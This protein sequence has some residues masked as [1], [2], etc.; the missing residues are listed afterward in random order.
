MYF[1]PEPDNFNLNVELANAEHEYITAL[2]DYLKSK[3]LQNIFKNKIITVD[4]FKNK[5]N[6]D[7]DYTISIF[8]YTPLLIQ[9]QEHYGIYFHIHARD[10]DKGKVVSEYLFK[11]FHLRYQFHLDKVNKKF[12]VAKSDDGNKQPKPEF[13]NDG[14]I[15]FNHFV[16]F[17]MEEK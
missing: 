9:G 17:I 13:Q 4:E 6:Q 3:G 10:Y 1:N 7:A 8:D 11:L 2:V 5:T 16:N 15:F 12:L 14:S